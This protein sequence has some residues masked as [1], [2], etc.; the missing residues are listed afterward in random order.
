MRPPLQSQLRKRNAICMFIMANVNGRQVTW[1]PPQSLMDVNNGSACEWQWRTGHSASSGNCHICVYNG[2]AGA[3]RSRGLL[4]KV[5]CGSGTP[6]VR[7]GRKCRRMGTAENKVG[8]A[9]ESAA[10]LCALALTFMCQVFC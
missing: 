5:S 6:H 3:D 1:L 10:R 8:M 4:R 7:S 9:G 2:S